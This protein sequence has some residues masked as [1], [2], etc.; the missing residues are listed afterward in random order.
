M[1]KKGLLID[2]D[3]ELG[4]LVEIILNPMGVTVDQAYSGLE[5]LK[6]FYE[7]RPDLVLLDVNL[8]G[9]NGFEV[10]A[11]LREL[12][13]V[14]I[15]MLTARTSETDLLRGFNLGVDDYVKKPFNKNELEARS[16]ALL[17]RSDNDGQKHLC[18]HY[19]VD[20]VLE[21]DLSAETV[22]LFGRVVDLSHREYTLLACLVRNQDSLVPHSE[23]I[24]EV[25]GEYQINA[26]STL[27]LYICYLRKKLEDG[28][29][30][31]EYIHTNW[32]QGYWFETRKEEK[33]ASVQGN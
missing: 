20:P 15:L 33:V 14:P 4:K 6:K 13:N 30:G 3:V 23:L 19:Y 18:I 12:S 11:R 31:H 24:R 7:I 5:G 29:H 8:P 16:R 21:I 10:C 26:T 9:M 22:R 28:Q 1:S 27:S 25:L 32:G 2:D 17:R